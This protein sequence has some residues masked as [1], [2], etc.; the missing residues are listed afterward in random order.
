MDKIIKQ[1]KDIRK[2]VTTYLK[3]SDEKK[4]KEETVN[5]L[6]KLLFDSDLD[7]SQSVEIKQE[8]D[9]RCNEE[10]FKRKQ[11]AKKHISSINSLKM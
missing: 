2:N 7:T 9:K 4:N 6:M 10:M 3:L 1:I 8:F 5:L 11:T